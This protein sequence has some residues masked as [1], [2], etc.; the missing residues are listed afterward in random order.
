M[1]IVKQVK[2]RALFSFLF[3]KPSKRAAASVSA[4]LRVCLLQGGLLAA[5]LVEPRGAA[6]CARVPGTRSWILKLEVFQGPEYGREI[7]AATEFPRYLTRMVRAGALGAALGAPTQSGAPDILA[8]WL[9]SVRYARVRRTG[10]PVV[11]KEY[12]RELIRTGR[13]RSGNRVAENAMQEVSS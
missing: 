2:Q 7:P 11:I 13:S 5:A 3:Q 12:I 6:E 4:R 10:R 9:H 1:Q 8:R